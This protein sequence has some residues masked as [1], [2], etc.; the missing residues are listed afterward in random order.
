MGSFYCIP[1]GCAKIYYRK[2]KA[3]RLEYQYPGESVK[4]ISPAYG[5]QLSYTFENI[6]AQVWQ[7]PVRYQVT[8]Q[9]IT[10]PSSSNC[11]NPTLINYSY[12]VWGPFYDTYLLLPTGNCGGFKEIWI[13]SH[14]LAPLP[15]SFRS[16][17]PIDQRVAANSV[18]GRFKDVLNLTATRIDGQP[19]NCGTPAQCIFRVFEN[20]TILRFSR[21][22]EVCPTVQIYPCKLED[23]LNAITVTKFP[24]LERVEVVDYG[25]FQFGLNLYRSI[26]PDNCL[27]IYVNGVTAYI[28]P[29]FLPVPYVPGN[30]QFIAQIC[31]DESCPPPVYDVVCDCEC[32]DC[33][34]N[35]CAVVCGDVVC[36]YDPEGTA[37]EIIPIEE[38]CG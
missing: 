22:E 7:C 19:D 34:P 27:N 32:K 29:P 9:S 4:T 20:G 23:G 17:T 30:Y 21:T 18:Y 6:P 14:G 38:Y 31:S 2:Y 25:Y 35:T 8:W 10:F 11:N 33:P 16:P 15:S 1:S 36:C 13:R 37:I 3:G 26:I 5:G 28:P 12:A 24:Y